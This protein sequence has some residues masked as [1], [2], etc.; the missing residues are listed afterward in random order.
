MRRK[1]DLPV[2]PDQSLRADK[3]SSVVDYALNLALF[4]HAE[5]YVNT[6]L[7]RQD[8]NLPCART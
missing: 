2:P 4:R 7:P 5:D 8:L 3:H 6:V 1:M